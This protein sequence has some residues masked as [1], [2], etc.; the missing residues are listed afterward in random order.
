[1]YPRL[2]RTI[3]LAVL[4]GILSS[5]GSLEE[6]EGG[7]RPL[8]QHPLNPHYFEYRGAPLI[9]ITSGEHYGAVLNRAFDYP[10]YLE[11]LKEAGLNN[12]RVFAG[13]Y[14]EPPGAFN[15]ASNTL[16]AAPGDFLCPW[17]RSEEPGYPN[18]GNKFD[19]EC[20]DEDYFTRLRDFMMQAEQRGIIVEMNLFCPFYGDA[21]WR[22]SPMNAANNVNGVGDISRTNV[23]TLDKNGGLLDIQE[24]MVRKIVSELNN[25]DNLYFEICNEPYFGGVT[26]A[27]QDH[28]ADLITATETGLPQRHLISQNIANGSKKVENPHPNV[29]ILNFHYAHPPDAVAENYHLNRVIGDNETGFRGTSLEPYR[30]EAWD[31][32]I[33]GGGLFNHLDYSFTVGHERGTFPIPPSQP[34]TG[35]TEWRRQLKVLVDFINSF[36][37]LAMRPAPEIVAEP[38]PSHVSIRILAQGG[39]AYAV[40]L[41]PRTVRRTHFSV[42]WSGWIEPRFSEEYTFYTLSNDGVRLWVDDRLVIDHWN[43][44]SQAEDSGNMRLEAGQKYPIR[45]EYFQATGDALI[46]L[47]WAGASQPRSIVAEDYLTTPDGHPGLKG[48]YFAGQN[49]EDKKLSRIDEAIDF[50]WSRKSPF[51]QGVSQ[52]LHSLRLLLPEGNYQAEWI[53]PASGRSKRLKSFD[54]LGGEATLICPPFESD[55]ALRIL[56]K[57]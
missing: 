24:N 44:H 35:G 19:L 45:L 27:W 25:F 43:E 2:L 3:G 48:D 29:A 38:L 26:Q 20:W 34:G 9:V 21:Q 50:N 10:V 7:E 5:C 22:L 39:E 15:I 54:H 46:H 47:Q 11:T 30:I 57:P 56:A 14:V 13:P 16:A 41:S 18:G 51:D 31:F 8:A 36:D 53:D 1:M 37:F 33:A 32:V 55:L 52:A 12:T 42:R 4:S 49:M 23:Y 17:A 40:Y 6:Q 28:I